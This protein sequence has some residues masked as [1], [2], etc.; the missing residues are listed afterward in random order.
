MHI[1]TKLLLQDPK[2]PVSQ[3]IQLRGHLVVVE[4]EALSGTGLLLSGQ[5]LV[6]QRLY[7]VSQRFPW[8]AG[9]NRT[10]PSPRRA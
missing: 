8:R 9:A 4:N 3:A 2:G 1:D 10:M 6:S 7:L 5:K